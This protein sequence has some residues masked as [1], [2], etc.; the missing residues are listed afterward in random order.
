M[1]VCSE[2]FSGRMEIIMENNI[3]PLPFEMHM[4][5]VI[6]AAALLIYRFATCKRTYQ[7]FLSIAVLMTLFLKNG[8]SKFLFNCI[9]I[10]IFILTIGAFVSVFIDRKKLKAIKAAE[11]K[12]TEAVTEAGEAAE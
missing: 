3:F 4:G 1:L 7:L 10:V 5:F 11:N 12:D 9:G 6:I 2:I 8:I